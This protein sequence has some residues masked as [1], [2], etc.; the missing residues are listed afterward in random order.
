VPPFARAAGVLA[1]L[2]A[3]PLTLLALG[4]A[5]PAGAGGADWVLF[6]VWPLLQVA[7]GVLL[8]AGRSWLFLA[9]ATVPGIAL[10]AFLFLV[11]GPDLG[12]M[13]GSVV[14]AALSVGTLCLAL[15][16][17]SRDWVERAA[18]PPGGQRGRAASR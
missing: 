14:Q 2:G 9:L 5:P 8:L 18:R 10:M 13:L 1:L 16:E 15:H 11:S 4:L 6:L 12:E 7:G 17:D 3:L